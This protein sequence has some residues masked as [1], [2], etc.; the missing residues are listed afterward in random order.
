MGIKYSEERNK[1]ISMASK[2]KSYDERY[3]KDKAQEIL[4]KK[5]GKNCH[6]WK[7]GKSYE[8][9]PREFS[10]KFSERNLR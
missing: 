4:K 8:E 1:K 10:K 2:G 6:W 9:Y 5:S 3:G 7:G